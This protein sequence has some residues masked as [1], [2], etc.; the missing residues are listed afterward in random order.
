MGHVPSAVLCEGEWSRATLVPGAVQGWRGQQQGWFWQG[1]LPA[2][3][4]VGAGQAGNGV[5]QAVQHPVSGLSITL[6][7]KCRKRVRKDNRKQGAWLGRKK[8]PASELQLAFEGSQGGTET[9]E[10]G[11]TLAQ[12]HCAVP[13]H[14]LAPRL[15]PSQDL[16]Q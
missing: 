12:W 11:Y 16:G 6:G 5:P 8:H 3:S 1:M 4:G 9:T 14:C 10:P 15:W 7:K 2:A 13:S